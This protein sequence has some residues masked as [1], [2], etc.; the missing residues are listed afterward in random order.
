MILLSWGHCQDANFAAEFFW[1]CTCTY[2]Q[3]HKTY[4]YNIYYRIMDVGKD[5]I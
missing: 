1:K 5:F 4:Y 3:D 2:S